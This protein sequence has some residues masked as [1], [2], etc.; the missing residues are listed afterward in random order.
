MASALSALPVG[1]TISLNVN[2]TAQEFIVVHQGIPDPDLYDASCD[3]TWLMMKNL[4]SK[5]LWGSSNL[6]SSAAVHT[7]LNG[8]FLALLDSTVQDQVRTVKIPYIDGTSPHS[9]ADGLEAKVF[10][11]SAYEMGWTSADQPS[12]MLADGKCLAYFEDFEAAD[13]RRIATLNGTKTWYWTR[14]PY[15]DGDSEVWLVVSVDGNCTSREASDSYGVRPVL[16]LPSSL[17]VDDSG[18]L[19]PNAA[20]TITSPS[21]TSGTSLGIRNAPFVLEYTAT[22]ADGTDLALTEQLD[23][24][25]TRTLTAASGAPQQFEALQDNAVFLPLS[26]G[27]HTLTVT[28]SDGMESSTLSLTF[29]RAVTSASLTLVQPMVASG[30]ISVATMAVDGV[31]PADADYTV[32]VTNNALD[33]E[34]IWQDATTEVR[35]GQNILFTNKTAEKSPAFNFR[36]R[37]ARG[38]SGTG[39]SITSITGAFQ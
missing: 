36:I 33:P 13:S 5:R 16:I 25:T 11:L 21:G 34:P 31:I 39:G 38:T 30:P 9:G 19:Q 2:N 20:P 24:Q 12:G 22:D 4:Y 35:Q 10:L 14:S 15:T 18:N 26:N 3:G 29:T 8:S 1:S 17:S 6:Y 32:E 23:G 37:A 7:W 27:T 28:A